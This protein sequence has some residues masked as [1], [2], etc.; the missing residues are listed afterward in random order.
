MPVCQSNPC[1]NGIT[2]VDPLNTFRLHTCVY[3]HDL[4][5]TTVPNRLVGGWPGEH[6]I[7]TKYGLGL[8]TPPNQTFQVYLWRFEASPFQIAWN[9]PSTSVL[10]VRG[11]PAP[12]MPSRCWKLMAFWGPISGRFVGPPPSATSH[13]QHPLGGVTLMPVRG[14][15][16]QAVINRLRR[17]G[18]LPIEFPYTWGTLWTHAWRAIQAGASQ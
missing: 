6:F 18:F 3:D 8:T 14:C 13:T 1:L 4:D 10:F 15:V 12:S 16:E 2:C 11:L 17:F 5:W 7:L 9:F